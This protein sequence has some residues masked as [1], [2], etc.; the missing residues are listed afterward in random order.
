MV[1]NVDDDSDTDGETEGEESD[2]EEP[3]SAKAG[4]QKVCWCIH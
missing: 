3:T 1:N 2:D 4:D